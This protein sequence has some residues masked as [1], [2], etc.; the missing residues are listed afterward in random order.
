MAENKNR[1]ML[2]NVVAVIIGALLLGLMWRVRGTTGWGSSWG[3]LNAGYIFTMFLI[4][5]KGTRQKLNA[6]WVGMTALSFMLT[7]PGWG[8]LLN[9]ISGILHEKGESE[10]LPENVYIPIYSAVFLMLCLGFGLATLFGIMLGRGFS[11]KQWKVKDFIILLVV[12]Y[13]V[14]L[15]AKASVSHWIL[16]LIQPQAAEVFEVH[17]AAEG[18]E[19]DAYKAFLEHFNNVSWAKKIEGGRNYFASVQAISAVFRSVAAIIATRFI[20]KDKISARTGLVVSGAFA[21]AI[22]V[23][24]LF[25]YFG[26]GGYHMEKPSYFPESV[27]PWS[28]WEF[29]TGLIAGAII[30]IFILC[31]KK[32]DDVPELAFSKVP[33]KPYTVMSFIMGYLAMI[34]INIVR[35]ILDR[36]EESDYHI[37][38]IVI[39][40]LFTLAI[41]FFLC[42]KLGVKAQDIDM[43]EYSKILVPL[44]VLFDIIVYMF[45]GAEDKPNYTSASSAHNI[46][47][48][49]SVV[50]ILIW[51]L[52]RFKKSKAK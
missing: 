12:F 1:N 35:P 8:T 18:H 51:S 27:Y 44:F 4:I 25:F 6:G 34:G 3:L 2:Q 36:M 47:C 49:I 10:I 19:A 11:S 21:F 45:I 50:L 46:A 14:D 22:T 33:E 9:Q 17:L 30:T 26:N 42:K 52:T 16:D 39:A 15:I 23:A 32:E 41:I 31:L 29:S 37:I 20:I 48:I 40:V 43:V 5:I 24:D 28:C 38:S 13:A 7:T